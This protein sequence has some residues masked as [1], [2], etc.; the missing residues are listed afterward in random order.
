MIRY[1]KSH[2]NATIS[3]IAGEEKFEES[4]RCKLILKGANNLLIGVVYSSPNCNRDNHDHLRLLKHSATKVNTSHILIMGDFNYGEI[5]WK[6]GT[7]P[8]ALT[9]PATAFLKTL[10]DLYLHQHIT[11]PTHYRTDQHPNTLDLVITNEEGMVDNLALNAPVGKSHHLCITFDFMCCTETP[12]KKTPNF[13][14]DKG[15]YVAMKQEVQTMSWT[16]EG[17]SSIEEKWHQLMNNIKHLMDKHIPKSRSHMQNERKRPICMTGKA[18]EKASLK[19][20]TRL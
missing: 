13:Q 12:T 11:D 3:H 2:L 20:W 4:L 18:K 10:G 17:E 16:L 1:T 14:Y 15:D 6:N 8:N 7:S 5:K 19:K 9:N